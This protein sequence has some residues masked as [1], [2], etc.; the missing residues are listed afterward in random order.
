MSS[1]SEVLD[2]IESHRDEVV[3]FMQTLLQTRS[4][5]GNESEIGALVAEEMRQDGL[6]V[7][8]VEPETD[9]VNALGSYSGSEGSPKMMTYS[10]YD[11][12][13]AGDLDAWEHPPFSGRIADGYIWSR[14]ACDNKIATCGLT[15]AFRA[16]METGVELKGDILFTHVG[17]EERGGRYGFREV[18]ERGYGEDIDYLFYAHG[19]S[20]DSIGVA[21]NGSR[22][23]T[24]NVRGRSAHTARLEEGVNAVVK[25]AGLIMKLKELADDVNSRAYHLPGTDSIMRSRFSINKCMGY[26]ANNNV[27][28]ECEVYID[29]RYT[30][31]ETKEQ[32]DEEYEGVINE[33]LQE[34]PDLSLDYDIHEGNLVSVA[35]PDSEIVRGIQAAAE[36]VLGFRS[37]PTGGS[38]SSDH[39]WFVAKHG[40]PYASY[41][42]GGEGIHSANERIKLEDVIYT[43]KVY[44]LSMIN[45]LGTR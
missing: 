13:P 20:G 38:H 29:R 12:V 11:T 8:L 28:D 2:Y 15:M 25:A 4:V 17:D 45:I 40:K 6:R 39:G 7:D 14:G 10:H 35:P 33:A 21:A 3:T 31:A 41:G 32:I 44:A 9:R 5:T 24:I 26:V 36:E 42:V 19:G 34:D 18:L 37:Q 1:N 30:P 22:G 27:P 23:C 16:L 43:T